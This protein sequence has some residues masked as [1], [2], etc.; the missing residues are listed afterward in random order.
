MRYPVRM[1][2]EAELRQRFIAFR[3]APEEPG[4]LEAALLVAA[5][6][7]PDF[8]PTG[9]RARLAAMTSAARGYVSGH[10]HPRAR[11]EGLCYYLKDIL[12]LVGDETHYYDRDNSCI[13]RVLETGRGIP[14]SL[15]VIYAEV[16]AGLG[17]DCEGV[18]FPGHFL[19]RVRTDDVAAPPLLLDPFAGLV[20]SHSECQQY[21]QRM[22]GPEQA[23]GPEHLRRATSLEVLLR[24]LNNL[25]QLAYSNQDL[26]LALRHS[27]RIQ[28]AD[29]GQ[30]LEHRDRALIHE[31][32]GDPVSATAEWLALV[33]VIEEG[34]TKRRI[35]ER[36]ERLGSKAGSG[37]VVH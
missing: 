32:L 28:L 22:A 35:L 26:S 9:V 37:R 12:G 7:R 11:V 31:Q 15:A 33:D 3:D 5:C 6:D 4:M 30:R 10:P 29:P 21:L 8:E 14:I 16:G 24:M 13:D 19:L 23:L 34:D 18:N 2:T 1:M 20:I 36:I 17:L 27:E 25:K